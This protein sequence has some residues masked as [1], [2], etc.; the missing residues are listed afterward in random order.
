MHNNP[1]TAT[2]AHRY[3]RPDR[4]P[5]VAAL[6]AAM[7][8]C[9]PAFAAPT[10]DFDPNRIA[11]MIRSGNHKAAYE[12]V[13]EHRAESEGQPAY[14]FWYGVAAL[15]AGHLSEG[16]FALERVHL[17]QP[18]SARVRLELARGYFLT[19][20]D[21][22]ARRH[23]EAVLAQNP[24]APVT[25]TIERYLHAIQQRADRYMTV[26]TGYAEIG[27]GYDSNVN[28]ATDA[29]EFD[30][31]G[32][33]PVQLSDE[34][35]E[36]SDAFVR[37]AAGAEIRRPLT[38]ETTFFL[39]GDIEN[40]GHEEHDEFNTRMGEVRTG[41]VFHQR[42]DVQTRLGLRLQRF[43]VGGEPY[44]DLA[45]IDLNIN[46]R[47][48]PDMAVNAGFQFAHQSYE[49]QETRNGLLAFVSAGVSRIWQAPV[50]P[51]T[52]FGV[53]L[54]REDPDDDSAS[55]R[56]VAERRMA[57]I[58]GGLRLRLRPEWNLQA[59]LQYRRSEYG[60]EH[61]LLGTTRE[62]DYYQADVVL[63]WQP[64]TRWRV[65]P[66]LRYSLNDANNELN[67][68]ERTVVELRARYG[69]H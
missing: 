6:L 14:D 1:R 22:R 46:H 25:A 29:A 61:V 40:T 42:E 33:L 12:Q 11:E 2:G 37:T 16:I 52:S 58:T 4:A 24:P 38:P 19:G 65:G 32:V 26:V 36:Q 13:L 27:G 45:G 55:A 48:S 67:E 35:R 28:S 5:A 21:R 69:F 7:L 43:E 10:H 63:D 66:R 23:F 49:E 44:R 50:R 47:A 60:A 3:P 57:G 59:G 68:Y 31:F 54:G 51:V 53:F 15:E 64:T 62:E 20:E 30:L 39:A 9:A 8:L 18:A 17:H 56:A 41:T 34:S